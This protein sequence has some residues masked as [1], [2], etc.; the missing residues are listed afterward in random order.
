MARLDDRAA[1]P[2]RL[3]AFV[4]ILGTCVGLAVVS[5]LVDDGG[6]FGFLGVLLL[7]PTLW[8]VALRRGAWQLTER[9]P[10]F[11]MCVLGVVL[12]C[13]AGTHAVSHTVLATRGEAVEVE[14]LAQDRADESGDRTYYLFRASDL[15]MLP[16]TLTIDRELDEDAVFTLLID[17]EGV[18]APMYPEDLDAVTWVLL[19]VAGIGLLAITVIGFGF[20]LGDR[21]FKAEEVDAAQ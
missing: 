9:A 7:A 4:V 16:D 15:F 20:P 1:L 18:V 8:F 10:R 5:A 2:H 11:W 6:G 12:V 3:L 13:T 19:A 17:P 21:R 14:V